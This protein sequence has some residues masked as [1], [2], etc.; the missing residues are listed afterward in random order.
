M[1]ARGAVRLVPNGDFESSM[2]IPVCCES[3]TPLSS[4]WELL[5]LAVKAQDVALAAE[6]FKEHAT[7]AVPLLPPNAFPS[8]PFPGAHD[9]ALTLS[10]V[11][12][13][14]ERPP[15]KVRVL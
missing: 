1:A 3:A 4:G 8:R 7:P 14:A 15:G 13:S 2:E 12:P 11:E 10:T 9:H 6:P 5:V